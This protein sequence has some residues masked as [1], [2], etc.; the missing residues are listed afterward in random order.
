MK[1]LEKDK[2]SGNKTNLTYFVLHRAVR[3][4]LDIEVVWQCIK[5][6]TTSDNEEILGNQLKHSGKP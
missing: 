3:R 4:K 6:F 5:T 2:Q 1:G